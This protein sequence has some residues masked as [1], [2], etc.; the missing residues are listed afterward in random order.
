ME[1]GKHTKKMRSDEVKFLTAIRPGFDLTFD[2]FFRTGA[3]LANDMHQVNL[4]I[5]TEMLS[6]NRFVKM[7]FKF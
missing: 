5:R 1:N 7:K 4:K 6:M 2:L 3:W